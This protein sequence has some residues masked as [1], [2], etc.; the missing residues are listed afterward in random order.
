MY[1]TLLCNLDK[2]VYTVPGTLLGK[3]KK[4]TI[5]GGGET[6]LSPL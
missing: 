6:L 2:L 4:E 3:E 5:K 1:S